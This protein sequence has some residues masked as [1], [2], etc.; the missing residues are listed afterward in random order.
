MTPEQLVAADPPLLPQNTQVRTGVQETQ[1]AQKDIEEFTNIIGYILLAFGFIALFVGAFVIFNTLSITVA[2]RVREFA[3]LRTIGASRRQ[4]LGSVI[5][6][7]LVIGLL[8]SVIGLFLGL[9]LAKGLT[10][11]FDSIGFDLPT[12]GLVFAGR[13]ILVS[14]LAG[15]LVTLVGRALPGDPRDARA[16]DRGGARGRDAPAVALAPLHALGR[17]SR[18]RAR[19]RASR[20]RHRS[21]T[22]SASRS[23]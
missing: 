15:V 18:D 13:T 21:S 11:L 3:T 16:A 4:I 6:E 8:A 17:R 10:A 2:Q 7:A 19:R 9:G 20:L 1:E 12:T 14:L 5:L 22:T 23:A